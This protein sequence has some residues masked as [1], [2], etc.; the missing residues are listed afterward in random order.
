[1][2]GYIEDEAAIIELAKRVKAYPDFMLHD[3]VKLGR[4]FLRE[5]AR[6]ELLRRSLFGGKG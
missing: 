5:A 4:P 3:A 1:M 6:R 2:S